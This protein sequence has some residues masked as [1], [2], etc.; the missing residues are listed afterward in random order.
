M[1]RESQGTLSYVICNKFRKKSLSLS[2]SLLQYYSGSQNE[3][4]YAYAR[5]GCVAGTDG[6]GSSA[7]FEGAAGSYEGGVRGHLGA[8][9][10]HADGAR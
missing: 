10:G 5:L 7:F 8:A 2:S 4:M 9:D 1:P 6:G 3:D